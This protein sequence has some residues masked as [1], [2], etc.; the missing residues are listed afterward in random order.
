MKKIFANTLTT[1]ETRALINEGFKYSVKCD[2]TTV[3][4]ELQDIMPTV[5]N[6]VAVFVDKIDAEEFAAAQVWPFNP[7]VHSKVEALRWG[8]TLE[9]YEERKERE[10]LERR[11]RR[12]ARKEK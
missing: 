1:E 11:A 6:N 8:E 9:E 4:T 7:D 2:F 12:A 5:K 10:K 3:K